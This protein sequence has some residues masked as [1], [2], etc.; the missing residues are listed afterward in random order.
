MTVPLLSKDE[1]TEV[2]QAF[3]YDPIYITEDKLELL[4]EEESF[5]PVEK[6]SQ[7]MIIENEIG[8]A[9]GARFILDKKNEKP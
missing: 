9:G 3:K 6:Y 5:V 7:W 2:I 4:K 8:V 1:F